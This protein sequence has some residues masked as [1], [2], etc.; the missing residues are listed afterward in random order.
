MRSLHCLWVFRIALRALF[1]Q[2]CVLAAIHGPMRLQNDTSQT[3]ASDASFTS[4]SDAPVACPVTRHFRNAETHHSA[5]LLYSYEGSGNTW[6]RYLLE[7]STGESAYPVSRYCNFH[8]V[9]YPPG[10][11]TGAI[12]TDPVLKK[13]GFLGEGDRTN[14]VI[15]VKSHFLRT[16]GIRSKQV[17]LFGKVCVF[18]LQI[19][20]KTSLLLPQVARRHR[21]PQ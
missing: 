10:I 12:Y 4:S 15:A 3:E 11:Y 17:L 1:L 8:A 9:V 6:V 2:S 16:P 14:K 7:N 20:R 21:P 19:G 18:S 5:A 13:S